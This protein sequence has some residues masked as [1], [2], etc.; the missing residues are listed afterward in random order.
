MVA[1]RQK[2]QLELAFDLKGV[3]EADKGK[4][5]GIEAD[6]AE[7]KE[8]SSAIGGQLMEEVCEAG[9]CMRA[10]KQVKANRGSAGVDGMTVAELPDY[11]KKH[12]PAIRDQLLS[13]TYNPQPVKRVEIPKLEGGKRKL[14]IP[15]VVDRFIQ[16]AVMQVLQK[17]WDPTFSESSY[18]FRPGKSAHQAVAQAQQY[19]SEGYRWVVDIDLEKFFDRV[20]HD[21]LMAAVAKRVQDKRML[22]LIRAFLNA[23][24]MENGLAS[25]VDEGTPQGGPLSP[26]LSNIVLD[27]LDR[28]LE[29]RKHRFARYADDCNIYVGSKRAG[30]RVMQ[31]VS[32]YITKRLKLKVN[33]AKSAVARPWERKFLGLSFTS[34]RKPKR[35]IAP[36]A[37]ERFKARATELTRRTRGVSMERMVSELSTYLR[38][39]RGYFGFCETPSTLMN[40]E[41][42]VRRRLRSSYWKQWK[43]S[44]K[45]FAELIKRGVGREL[46]LKTVGSCHGPW[47]LSNSP[48]LSKALPN[49]LFDSLGLPRLA[50][51]R[52]SN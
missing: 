29:K 13:G 50:V 3:G 39:W 17:R 44:G 27:E 41:E 1:K 22:K 43:R 46:A 37:I 28:Q 9:N 32:R 31:W 26:L 48:A 15:T 16:Q 42:W 14:G 25:P 10:I 38:G 36:K 35:R 40:L 11:L 12:W 6:M 51:R 52:Q 33:S 49:S 4:S 45:R 21:K 19:M 5:E 30:E 24:V 23:G 18:G 34:D 8:E 47:R 7:R 2:N 20:N